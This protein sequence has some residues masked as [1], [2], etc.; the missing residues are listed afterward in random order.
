MTLTSLGTIHHCQSHGIRHIPNFE[1]LF[2]AI[3]WSHFWQR[4][5]KIFMFFTR[6]IQNPCWGTSNSLIGHN[7]SDLIGS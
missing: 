2:D 6:N 4:K 3:F 5:V 1:A 7:K